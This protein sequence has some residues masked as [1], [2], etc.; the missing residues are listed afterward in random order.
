MRI[1]VVKNLKDVHLTKAIE[2]HEFVIINANFFYLS[3]YLFICI[4]HDKS[5]PFNY[6]N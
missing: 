1:H 5:L 6:F 2:K 4:Y 3:L